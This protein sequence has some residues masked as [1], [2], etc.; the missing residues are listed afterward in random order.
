M[1]DRK[2]ET[3]KDGFIQCKKLMIPSD[4][5]LQIYHHHRR[6]GKKLLQIQFSAVK[7]NAHSFLHK[8]EQMA[9][10]HLLLSGHRFFF[11][12][13]ATNVIKAKQFVLIKN[14]HQFSTLSVF[15][16]YQILPIQRE[17]ILHMSLSLFVTM[18]SERS[19]LRYLSSLSTT[20][21][22]S[23]CSDVLK[24][25]VTNEVIKSHAVFYE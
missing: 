12:T 21:K 25:Q 20:A 7:K 1:G 4:V 16:N 5:S 15:L 11:S 23:E 9:R 24:I 19:S 17:R 3:I 22:L 6:R 10:L 8:E 18:D 2:K 13:W 14:P